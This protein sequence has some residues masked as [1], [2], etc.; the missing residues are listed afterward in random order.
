MQKGYIRIAPGGQPEEQQEA[1]LV[2]ADVDPSDIYREV[3]IKRRKEGAPRFPQ[4]EA[5][6]RSLRIG[7]TDVV[8]IPEEGTL[9]D[10]PDDTLRALAQIAERGA[11]VKVARTGKSYSFE[12]SAAAVLDLL[13]DGEHQRRK[14][15][16]AHARVALNKLGKGGVPA[17]QGKTKERARRAYMDPARSAEDVAKEFG[18]SRQTLWATFGA[19]NTP[20]ATQKGRRR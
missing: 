2:R 13:R 8:V 20:D 15:R 4:R 14:H 19:K 6:I 10:S 17:L 11:V 16:A 1:A 18:V 12:P 7:K 9:G 3:P 5:M